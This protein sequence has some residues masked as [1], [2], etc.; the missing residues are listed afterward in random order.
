MVRVAD[1]GL[2]GADLEDDTLEGFGGDE[3]LVKGIEA[4]EA[5]SEAGAAE[6]IGHAHGDLDMGWADLAGH[7]GGTGGTFD[8]FCV[9]QAEEVEGF[10]AME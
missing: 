1:G 5:E 4:R 7:A 10:A 3:G 2:I 6:G 9:E 8:A